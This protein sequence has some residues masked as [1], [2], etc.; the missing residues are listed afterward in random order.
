MNSPFNQ[1]KIADSHLMVVGCGALGN[2]VLKNLVL[3]GAEHL[4]VVDFDR[5]EIGN[6]SRSIL[7]TRE[8]AEA[9]R[10]KVDV[11]A[12]RLRQ[13]NSRLDIQTIQGDIA[14]DVG[15]GLI[16]QMDVVIGCVDNRWARYCINRHCMRCGISWVDGAIDMLEGTVRVFEPG[17]NCYACNLGPKGLGDLARRMPC[18][19]HRLLCRDCR[20]PVL[21]H[22]VHLP[23]LSPAA[24]KE[25]RFLPS[26]F[27][28]GLNS[29]LPA[30]DAKR[31][32]VTRPAPSISRRRAPPSPAQ[33]PPFHPVPAA[34]P[35]GGAP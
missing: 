28:H 29:L 6:L 9:G 8:D 11:V 7:F 1:S 19:G 32:E 15:L 4:T 25:G 27:P 3:M 12:S 35:C 13:M 22:A 17:R 23:G 31:H 18:A 5:V 16:R 14:Y 20:S 34:R 24:G 33:P 10:Y 21:A 2:E 30:G 26:A